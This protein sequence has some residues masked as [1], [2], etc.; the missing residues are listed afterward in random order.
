MSE[1][2]QNNITRA[3]FLDSFIKLYHNVKDYDGL[4]TAF[5]E[6]G[7]VNA[8][9]LKAKL[10]DHANHLELTGI[11]V[12]AMEMIGAYLRYTLDHFKGDTLQFLLEEEFEEE[13]VLLSDGYAELSKNIEEIEGELHEIDKKIF[14]L[15]RFLPYQ[16]TEKIRLI[17]KTISSLLKAVIR[18]DTVDMENHIN[19]IHHLTANKESYFL[20][21]EIGQVVRNIH[22]SLQDFSEGV[23]MDSV[24]TNIVDE[25]P[26]AVDKLN[27]VIHRMETAANN[28]L[29]EVEGLL[30]RNAERQEA[31]LMLLE[32]V[33]RMEESLGAI[34]ARCPDAA[35]EVDKA[36]AQ[37]NDK[38][39]FSFSERSEELKADETVYFEIIGNQSFQD[40]TGQTIK[41]II[42]FI[43]QLE[44][45]LL[46][47]LQKY[48]GSMPGAPAPAPT[49]EAHVSP[50]QGKEEDGLV[51]EGPQDNSHKGEEATNQDDIDK[52]LAGFGF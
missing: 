28:T 37:L 12:K 5:S 46:N 18:K 39:A 1:Q 21:T 9:M 32:E 19:H 14:Y 17:I 33:G 35:E 30:D 44:I 50:L 41:K 31:N 48:S 11:N 10:Q 52:M 2:I 24:N 22:Q 45:N 25:M 29:D 42:K 34:K 27:L 15:I 13:G 47:I 6:G 49:E 23:P 40:I 20:I 4:I 43:E 8:E 7:E 51:L 26:D 16:N 38:F 36:M 3:E